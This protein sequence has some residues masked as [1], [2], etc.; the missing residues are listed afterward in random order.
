MTFKDILK[1]AGKTISVIALLYIFLVSISLLSASFKSFG[2]EFAHRLIQTTSNPFVGLFIGILATTIIQS[3]STTTSMIVG[4][5]ASGAL[6]VENA[7]PMVMGANIGTT[8]T[9][10]LVSLGHITRKEEFKRAM[11]CSSVHDLFNM[12]TVIILLPLELA[13][14]YLRRAATFLAGRFGQYGGI[15]IMN[16]LKAVIKPVVNHIEQTLT[17]TTGLQPTP[18]GIIM[19]VLA[20]VLLFTALIFIVKIMKSSTAKRAEIVFNK[21]LG[22][23]SFIGLL[24][25]MTFT[26][27]VQSSSITTSILVPVVAAG[28]TTVET[29]FPIT[30]G[31]NIGTTV[32]AIL[33]ALTGNIAGVTIAFVHLLFNLTGIAIVYNIR[34][35]RNAIIGAAKG[36]AN[37]CTRHRALALVYVFGVFYIF[38]GLL[39]FISKLINK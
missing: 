23:S 21:I 36:L 30:M 16:P 13:T 29:V 18:A 7:V 4:F 31:A 35:I 8:V 9:N 28:I 37:I 26:A 15:K 25:G 1:K 3:S 33:A 17:E 6:T 39:I 19:L 20:L 10:T 38:P 32:T 14:G 2:E 27:I 22:R 5:V 24:M 11:S 12:F 34:V